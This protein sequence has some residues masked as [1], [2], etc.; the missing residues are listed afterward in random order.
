MKAVL[1]FDLNDENDAEKWKLYQHAASYSSV[2]FDF[3]QWLRAK[4]K[5][6]CDEKSAAEAFDAANGE[7]WRL[8]RDEGIDP[9]GG[10]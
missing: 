8:C 10:D 2:L 6:G 5:Y 7:F 4:N 3:A 1:R 9:L